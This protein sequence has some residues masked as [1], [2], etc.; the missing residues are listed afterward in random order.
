MCRARR[1]YVSSSVA[2]Y[3]ELIEPEKRPSAVSERR[4]NVRSPQGGPLCRA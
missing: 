3:V 4:P 1:P 2:L